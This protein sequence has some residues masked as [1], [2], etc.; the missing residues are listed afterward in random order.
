MKK[1]RLP[2]HSDQPLRKELLQ[3][4]LA[5]AV[6]W[7]ADTRDPTNPAVLPVKLG[8]IWETAIAIIILY[9][10][11][12]LMVKEGSPTGE[13][14]DKI[15]QAVDFLL[16]QVQE[17]AACASWDGGLYDTSLAVRALLYYAVKSPDSPWRTR[18]E[19]VVEKGILWLCQ[20]V[21]GWESERYS[22]GVADLAQVLQ[23]ILFWEKLKGKPLAALLKQRKAAFKNTQYEIETYV[24]DQL[25]SALTGS[26]MEE[27]RAEPAGEANL[28]P[29]SGKGALKY[30]T[31]WLIDREN[32]DIWNISEA[33]MGLVEYYQ[34]HYRT[35][36]GEDEAQRL[37][38]VAKSIHEAVRYLEMG[39]SDGKWGLPDTSSLALL[40]YLRGHSIWERLE[41]QPQILFKTIRWLCDDKQRFADGSLLHSST[42][43]LFFCLCLVEVV[44]RWIPAGSPLDLSVEDLYDFV[45]WQMP[46][47]TSAERAK[48]LELQN[49]LEKS[50]LVIQRH[51]REIERGKRYQLALFIFFWTLLALV[52]SWLVGFL[53]VSFWVEPGL[54]EELLAL[55][56]IFLTLGFFIGGRIIRSREPGQ[57]SNAEE[58]LDNF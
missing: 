31:R 42:H 26:A 55:L 1:T 25:I 29:N 58:E 34:R 16:K 11:K 44:E 5:P 18:I 46:A 57:K 10:Y 40:A 37:S 19:E 32:Q 54:W 17:D 52:V 49:K 27:K 23:T 48:R 51:R 9:R 13:F 47:R 35:N 53:E 38:K 21:E 14:D 39:H 28:N 8:N 43:T 50:D 45:L 33:V 41:P 30:S 36:Y 22:L 15:T 24:L 12:H 56:S 6:R 3:V 4:Y 20:E 2:F 7:I